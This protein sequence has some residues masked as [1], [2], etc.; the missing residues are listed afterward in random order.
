MCY[1]INGENLIERELMEN[2]NQN[3]SQNVIQN[4]IDTSKES[5]HCKNCS[6]IISSFSG[7]DYC[8]FICLQE[9]INNNRFI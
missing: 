3:S 6:A 8:D 7:S 2:Q 1:F 4:S 5:N 9:A